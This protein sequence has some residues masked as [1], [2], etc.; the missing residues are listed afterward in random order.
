MFFWGG[1]EA[2]GLFR[3]YSEWMAIP[4]EWEFRVDDPRIGLLKEA[5]LHKRAPL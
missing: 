2:A 5:S 3:G 4:S 1:R